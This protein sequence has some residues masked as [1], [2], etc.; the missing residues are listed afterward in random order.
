MRRVSRQE[1]SGGEEV[2]LAWQ[3]Q[4][5]ERWMRNRTDFS[6]LVSG[7]I[8]EWH[9]VPAKAFDHLEFG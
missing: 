4:S 7:R 3:A 5:R 6:R 8:N 1:V 9:L 2:A